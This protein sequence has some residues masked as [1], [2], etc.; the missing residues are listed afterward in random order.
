MP[1]SLQGKNSCQNLKF[2][3]TQMSEWYNS[4]LPQIGGGHYCT[5]SEFY[6]KF[7]EPTLPDTQSVIDWTNLLLQYVNNPEAVYAIRAFFSWL[8]VKNLSSDRDSVLALQKGKKVGDNNPYSLRRGFLTEFP[9]ATFKYFFTDN[10][11]AAY[12]M[13]MAYDGFVPLLS[14]LL[15]EMQSG[16]FPGRFGPCCK[17]EKQVAAYKI[18]G[19][20]AKDPGINRLGY[21]IGHVIDAGMDYYY[22]VNQLGLA[23]ICARYFPRGNY[24]Q[25]ISNGTSRQGALSQPQT[26][27]F[28]KAHFLRFA[29]PI[30]YFLAPKANYKGKIYQTYGLTSGLTTNKPDIAELPE[31]QKYII[32][33]F[34]CLYGQMYEDYLVATMWRA[35]RLEVRNELKNIQSQL[36]NLGS[37]V[38]DL[39]VSGKGGAATITTPTSSNTISVAKSKPATPRSSKGKGIGGFAYAEISKRIARLTPQVLSDLQNKQYCSQTFR[40]SYPVLV[41]ARV[42]RRYYATA[43]NGYYICS[44]WTERNRPALTNWLQQNP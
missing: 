2:E 42:N 32:G 3:Y 37:I 15:T 39:D 14:D 43:V 44:Q 9:D 22:G 7:V 31:L 19:E 4:T 35:T 17:A 38:I 6:Q 5:I 12:F 11:F 21:K 13:K 16:K 8:K 23:D 20:V 1:L 26:L 25:W 36:S 30:N 41:T 33:Q 28:L 10:F 24:D 40:L 18:T 29:C 27:D 34:S